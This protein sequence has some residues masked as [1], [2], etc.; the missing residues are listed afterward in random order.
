MDREW[1]L[2]ESRVGKEIKNEH[3]KGERSEKGIRR[4]KELGEERREKGR[5]RVRRR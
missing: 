1:E 4:E 2:D 3:G 5:T